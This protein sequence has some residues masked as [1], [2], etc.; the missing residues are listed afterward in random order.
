MNRKQPGDHFA[1]SLNS[2]ILSQNALKSRKMRFKVLHN[3]LAYH[4]F[5]CWKMFKLCNC[6][7]EGADEAEQVEQVAAQSTQ[8]A[9]TRK[10]S[11]NQQKKPES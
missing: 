8:A 1:I 10:K 4:R 2:A 5:C 11:K 3:I 7:E 9:V 6:I